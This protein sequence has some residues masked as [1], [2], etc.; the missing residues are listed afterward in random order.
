M[1]SE[2]Y[3]P[4]TWADFIAQPIIAEIEQAC[5]DDWLFDGGGERGLVT[6]G[7][8]AKAWFDDSGT[9]V[10]A[11]VIGSIDDQGKVQG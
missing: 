9:V 5:G 2:R 4:K 10:D 7:S 6:Q 11:L 3:R 8:V 1:L